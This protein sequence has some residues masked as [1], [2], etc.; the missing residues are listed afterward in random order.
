MLSY[1]VT[2]IATEA[3]RVKKEE[4]MSTLKWE[5]FGYENNSKNS[6]KSCWRTKVPG[7]WIV[8]VTEWT[9]TDHIGGPVFIP[10]LYHE[11]DGNSLP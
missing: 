2:L 4:K 7:G 6:L 9:G 1:C 5:L 10:D 3:R 11:W 8:F